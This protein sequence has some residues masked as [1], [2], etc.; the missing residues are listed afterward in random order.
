MN[1]QKASIGDWLA[2]DLYNALSRFAVPVFVMISGALLLN[3]EY[4]LGGF[5]KKRL[6][7]IIWPFLLWSLVYVAYSWYDEEL[8]F[9]SDV[10]HNIILV[11]HQLKYGAYYHLWY[12]YMLIG[13]YL[14]IPIISRFVRNAKEKEIKYFLVVW[15]IVIAFTQP[16]LSRFWPQVDVRYFTGY[17]GYLVLG[18]Y[19]V[20]KELP[21]KGLSI[22]LWIFYILCLAGITLGT[23]FISVNTHSLSMLMYEPLGPFVILYASGIFLLARVMVFHLPASLVRLRDIAGNYSLGIYLCHALFLT[24]MDDWGISY[25]L[26]NPYISIP[27]TA[28]VCFILSFVLIFILSKMPVIG[29]YLAG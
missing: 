24:L 15:F 6:T 10:W 11:L 2:S 4:E 18:H 17:I 28:L 29:K 16:Y 19:L 3:K 14:I 13:L 9:N 5:L 27:V 21:E 25:K 1:F 12:V 22:L 7:R 20:H 23:Y 26:C 8:D